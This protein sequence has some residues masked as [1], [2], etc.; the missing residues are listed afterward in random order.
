[1]LLGQGLAWSLAERLSRME[2][3]NPGFWMV[4]PGRTRADDSAGEPGT[5][6]LYGAGRVIAASGKMDGGRLDLQLALLDQDGD[7]LQS[8]RFGD[9]LTNLKTWQRSPADWLIGILRPGT[10][11][12]LGE[13]LLAGGTTVPAAFR[14]CQI[15]L[16]RLLT[17]SRAGADYGP[18]IAD[19]SVAVACDSSYAL[20]WM[21]LGRALGLQGWGGARQESDQA[22]AGQAAACLARATALDP[23]LAWAQVYLG[24]L[25]ELVGDTEPALA[26]Y[27]RAL[28]ADPVHAQALRCLGDL[29]WKLGRADEAETT[30]LQAVQVRPGFVQA[31]NE[32]GAFYYRQ[33]RYPQAVRHFARVVELAPGNFRGFTLLGAALFES[34]RYAEAESLFERSLQLQPSFQAY[35]NLSTLYYYDSRYGDAIAMSRRALELAPD[36]YRLWM[37]QASCLWAEG[38][39]DSALA[40]FDKARTLAEDEL[41]LHPGDSYILADLAS[42][43]AHLEQPD[44]AAGILGELAGRSELAAEVMFSMADTYETMGSRDA[45]LTW[46]ERAVAADLSLKKVRR[47]PG[48]RNL[49]SDPRFSA[50]Q[51]AYG[52]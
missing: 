1:M 36:D 26:A 23:A 3:D 16:G 37:L 33:A 47:Y 34:G 52:E 48:L 18:A 6:D 28:A 13:A 24:N 10:D 19:F 49:R 8:H 30:Y 4:P 46:L 39:A 35:N 29:L 42:A 14:A 12:P 50:L 40:A 51:A 45:A 21:G 11:G 25:L 20:A 27:R 5:H 9:T 17:S 31:E 7:T 2:A 32:A 22:P 43:C 15:G 38:A 44:R 41:N